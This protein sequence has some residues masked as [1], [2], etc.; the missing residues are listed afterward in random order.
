MHGIAVDYDNTTHQGV[1]TGTANATTGSH[2]SSRNEMF[3]R[4]HMMALA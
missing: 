4:L 3:V 2:W 1:R